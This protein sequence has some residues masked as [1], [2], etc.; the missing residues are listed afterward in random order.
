[1]G[2]HGSPVRHGAESR[3]RHPAR[4]RGKR[5]VPQRLGP[6]PGTE[7]L[8]SS[9]RAHAPGAEGTQCPL[10]NMGPYDEPRGH[11]LPWPLTVIPTPPPPPLSLERFG[12]SAAG[13]ARLPY[14]ARQ[15]RYY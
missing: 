14:R 6:V 2:S 10:G 15:E 3:N 7:A 12:E 1:M 9:P 8:S 11:L 13:R 4:A 5:E